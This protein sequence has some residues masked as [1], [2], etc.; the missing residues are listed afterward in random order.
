MLADPENIALGDEIYVGGSPNGLENTFTKGII[1]GIRNDQGFI[2]I[3]AAISPGS[4]GGPVVN[5]AGD[6]VAIATASLS[7]GQNLNFA[8]AGSYLLAL[9][10]NWDASVPETGAFSVT[11]AENNGLVGRIKTVIT[12]SAEKVNP[13]DD[14]FSLRPRLD[15]RQT[16]N[17]EGN[18]TEVVY[19]KA[20]GDISVIQRVEYDSRGIRSTLTFLS[21]NYEPAK[22]TY[23][24]QENL[25]LK[26]EKR[27][28]ST[29][30]DREFKAKSGLMVKETVTFDRNGNETERMR[31]A[32]D[33]EYSRTLFEYDARDRCILEIEVRDGEPYS[34]TT[35]QYKFDAFGNWI[36][37]IS[38]VTFSQAS[39]MEPIPLDLVIRELTYF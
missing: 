36:Q 10:L 6:V 25:Q 8:V 37:K 21:T 9:R 32:S 29:T 4:S 13:D 22:R 1:S 33:G 20:S 19:Y 3:D 11:D 39:G 5:S 18:E 34:R 31:R 12:K 24:D 27:R 16:Y 14:L 35:H 23:T 15:S 28:Y 17:E 30:V 2:Q 7:S 26:L 38:F